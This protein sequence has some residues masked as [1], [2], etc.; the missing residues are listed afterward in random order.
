MS[1]R[2]LH[3]NSYYDVERVLHHA[4]R[5]DKAQRALAS[6]WTWSAKPLEEWDARIRKLRRRMM[7]Y[8]N[9]AEEFRRQD[10]VVRKELDEQN[11]EVDKC[12]VA[13]KKAFPQQTRRIELVDRVFTNVGP[14]H[15]LQF[16]AASWECIWEFLGQEWKPSPSLTLRSFRERRLKLSERLESLAKASN[17][18]RVAAELCEAVA[19]ELGK[20]CFEWATDAQRSFPAESSASEIVKDVLCALRGHS[21]MTVS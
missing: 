6:D 17:E 14:S 8:Q 15:R 21:G 20:Q 19:S 7:D 5:I 4:Q 10:A 1:S 3:S 16:R 13:A 12:L 2:L 11:L 9:A 18:R